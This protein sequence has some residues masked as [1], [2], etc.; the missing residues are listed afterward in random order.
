[1]TE[2]RTLLVYQ[3]RV[4]AQ[5]AGWH[6]ARLGHQKDPT[7]VVWW[8]GLGIDPLRGLQFS[9]VIV[10]SGVRY[11]AEWHRLREEI[12]AFCHRLEPMIWMEP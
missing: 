3:N 2:T 11:S 9:H 1:M 4:V 12:R 8:P 5:S 7:L 10:D 6:S